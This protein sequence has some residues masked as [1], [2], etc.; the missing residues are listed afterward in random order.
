MAHIQTNPDNSSLKLFSWVILCWVKLTNLSLHL[1]NQEVGSV[2]S[3]SGTVSFMSRQHMCKL[4]CTKSKVRSC[5]KTRLPLCLLENTF[6]RG[7]SA[8]ILLP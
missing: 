2:L 7:S 3:P 6:S 4:H 1:F 5:E 8:K